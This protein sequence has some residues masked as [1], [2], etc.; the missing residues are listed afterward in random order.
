M[1]NALATDR[2]LERANPVTAV[3]HISL[4]WDGTGSSLTAYL[5]SNAGITWLTLPK[6]VDAP[7][8]RTSRI[9][10]I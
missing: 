8:P 5:N 1:L 2:A 10:L 9:R 6:S 4:V 7:L 3:S